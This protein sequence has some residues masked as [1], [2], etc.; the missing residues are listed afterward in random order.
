M[1]DLVLIVDRLQQAY[2]YSSYTI[3]RDIVLIVVVYITYNYLPFDT[4]CSIWKVYLCI[5]L[6]RFALSELTNLRKKDSDKKYFQTSGHMALFTLSV[7]FAA[8]HNLLNL[9]Y[10]LFRN[11]LLVAYGILNVI[12]HAHY[13]TDIINTTFLIHFVYFQCCGN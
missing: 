11:A 5:L 10:V 3:L 13:T 9:H 2:D 1:S 12:V 4:F 8:Q 6:L 7:L